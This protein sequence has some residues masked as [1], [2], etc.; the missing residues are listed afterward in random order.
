M[1]FF[2]LAS[3]VV[4]LFVLSKDCLK[5]SRKAGVKN[6]Q[7]PI[8][9]LHSS[10]DTAATES[11]STLN[12]VSSNGGSDGD[13]KKYE[14]LLTWLKTIKKADVSSKLKI[15]PSSRGGGYG[16][17]VTEAVEKGESLFSIPREACITLQDAKDDKDCGGTFQKVMEKA[18]P[19]GN[20]VVMAGFMAKEQ[21]KAVEDVKQGKD[22]KQSSYFGPYLATLPWER[23][24]NNQEHTLYWPPELIE[25]Y[26]KGSMCYDE[27]VALRGEVDLAIT[28]MNGI[29]GNTVNDYR[30]MKDENGF[31]WPWEKKPAPTG[32]V[33]GLA[34]AV[35]G[36]FVSLLTRSFQDGDDSE[37]KMVP[38]LDML[39]HSDEPNISHV[40]RQSDGTVEVRARQALSAGDELLNQYISELEEAM[41]YHRFFTRFG[42]VP[43]IDEPILNLL[44]DKSTI[45]FAKKVEV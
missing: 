29:V 39:Q 23:G 9:R 15:K 16:A 22:L 5:G 38:L 28:V 13:S 42:F 36:A 32:P 7:R 18:G 11:P 35:T 45:F 37:E 34:P 8:V 40:M 33:D 27:A 3:T 43:G 20:T 12:T 21:L 19:G 25:T 26:L 41:P 31:R 17:F 4:S 2:G 30:G 24:D 14:D 10:S 6:C 44:K 1:H